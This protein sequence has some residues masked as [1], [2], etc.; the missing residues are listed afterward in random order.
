MADRTPAEIP[1]GLELRKDGTIVVH[2]DDDNGRNERINLRRPKMRELRQFREDEWNIAG[3]IR[4]FMEPLQDAV[5]D[6]LASKHCNASEPG[7]ILKLPTADLRTLRD[8]QRDRDQKSQI[9]SEEHR[10]PWATEVIETL[11]GKRLDEDGLPPWCSTA[12]FAG[13]LIGHWLMVPTRRGSP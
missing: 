5:D 3:E 6:F 1:E 12:E 10:I 8:L 2:V 9:F 7:D 4:A 13:H 11:S